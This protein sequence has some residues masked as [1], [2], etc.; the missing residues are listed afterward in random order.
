MSK[1]RI[2]EAGCLHNF[3]PEY[4]G[5][6]FNVKHSSCTVLDAYLF[7][8]R[9]QRKSQY[10]EPGTYTVMYVPNDG[11]VIMSD[12]PMEYRTNLFIMERARGHVLIGGLGFSWIVLNIQDNPDVL[13]IT[14]VELNPE[15][16][17]YTTKNS[18]L[19]EKVTVVQG[20]VDTWEPAK[21][22]KYDVIY[23]DI[24]NQVTRRNL[25]QMEALRK[26]AKPWLRNKGW[27]G[28]W[29][30]KTTREMAKEWG[31][32]DGSL[33]YGKLDRGEPVEIPVTKSSTPIQVTTKQPVSI[34]QH[35][36]SS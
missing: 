23:F 25:P 17:A 16:I 12:T 29:R 26:R 6:T 28:C 10:I 1:R 36:A 31:N 22:I 18:H 34:Y 2:Y 24:W 11:E 19:N 3:M 13:S 30:E 4:K 8:Q 35:G 32:D 15:V 33:Y 14:V 27:L 21:G 7:N 5:E 9:Q 20:D